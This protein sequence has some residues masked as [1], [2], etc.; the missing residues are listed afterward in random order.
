MRKR[1]V[2]FLALLLAAL[3]FT[4]CESGG[5]GPTAPSNPNPPVTP[6]P[7]TFTVTDRVTGSA[8]PGITVNIPGVAPVVTDS[9]GKA[10]FANGIGSA[11]TVNLDGPGYR[12]SDAKIPADRNLTIIRYRPDLGVDETFIDNILFGTLDYSPQR[13]RKVGANISVV[14]APAIAADPLAI[15]NGSIAKAVQKLSDGFAMAGIP[16]SASFDGTGDPAPGRI[17]VQVVVDRAKADGAWARAHVS[18]SS[19]GLIESVVI[20]CDNKECGRDSLGLQHELGHAIGLWH[21][22]AGI[23]KNGGKPVNWTESEIEAIRIL[24]R[25]KVRTTM[26]DDSRNSPQ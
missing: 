6:T 8:A 12:V 2:V 1:L 25:T 11:T 23:M 24:Y 19:D 16:I 3:S 15:S 5:G 18:T 21:S 10:T 17:P 14:V 26:R 22:A 4:A 7:V 13:T 20:S 9:D